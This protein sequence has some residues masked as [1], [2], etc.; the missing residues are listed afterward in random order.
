MSFELNH[1]RQAYIKLKSYI[2]HDNTDI[3]LRKNLAEFETNRV[4]DSETFKNIVQNPYGDINTFFN[5]QDELVEKKLSRLTEELNSYHTDPKFF[6]SFIENIKVKFYPKK[7]K[8]KGHLNNFITNKVIQENYEVERVTAFI[9]APIELHIIAVL[10][11]L[12]HGKNLDASLNDACLGNRLILN[13]EKEEVIQGSGL[14]KPYFHQYQKWR[15][16]SVFVAESLL[17]NKKDV[18]FLNLDIRDYYHSVRINKTKLFPGRTSKIDVLQP[19]YN[20]QEIFQKIHIFYTELVSVKYEVP[21]NL[22]DTMYKEEG[23]LSEIILPIGL[24]SSYVLGNDYLKDFDKRIIEKIKPAY[25][26]RYV[27]D[28]LIVISDPNPN[29]NNEEEDKELTFDFQKYS[30]YMNR[31]SNLPNEQVSFEESDLSELEKYILENFYPVLKIVDSPDFLAESKAPSTIEGRV[32]KI[33]SYPSLYCQSSKSLLYYFDYKES[34]LVIDKLKKELD[35]RTS[36]FRDFPDESSNDNTFEESAYHLQY[37]GTNGKIRTLKDYKENRFGLT[38][39]LSNKIF[40][41]L[42]HE[43][44][45]SEKEKDQVLQFFRGINCINFHRLWERIFTF[46]LVNNQATAYVDFYLHCSSQIEN[47]GTQSECVL[48]TNVDHLEIRNTLV[49]YLDCAHELSLS[50]NPSFIKKTQEAAIN[51]KY[52]I[53]KLEQQKYSLFNL[54]FEPTKPES[55]W[56]TRFRETNMVRHQYIVHPLLSYTV[57]SKQGGINLTSLK[58]NFA[59]YNFDEELIKSSPRRVKYWECCLATIFKKLSGFAQSETKIEKEYFLTNL[60]GINSNQNSTEKVNN[61]SRFYLDDAFELYKS[62]NQNHIPSY[63]MLDDEFKNKFFSSSHDDLIFD[64]WKPLNVQEIRVNSHNN[65]QL[66][67]PSIAFA[68]TE[69]RESNILDSIR[70]TP[71]LDKERYQNLGKVLKM[72]RKDKTDILLFP[73]CYIPINL[74]SSLVKHSAKEQV[75]VVSGLEHIVIDQLA[76]NFIVTILPVEV[77]GIKDA[78]VVIRLKNHYSPSEELLI[79]G[80]HLL[81]PKPSPYRYDIFIWRNVYLAPY[82]C[83]ELANAIHRN[84]FKG[85]VDLLIG[86]EWNK[87]TPYFSNIVE[88]TSRDLH[89]FIAQVN[90]SQYGDTRLTQPVESARKDIMRLKGGI[91]DAL[92]VSKINIKKLREFQRQKFS[93]THNKNEFKPLPPDYNLEDVLRRIN[94]KSVI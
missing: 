59:N 91:N 60:L 5:K 4:K 73:E 30:T 21:Y 3:L 37:D 26:G 90:T 57:D 28:I 65:N 85:K 31:T 68:N 69:V 27:D 86:V 14:F 13:K 76:F 44:K 67:E 23:V 56:I 1:V 89:A 78:V 19:Y 81:T 66:H 87:D 42:R 16:D 64:K 18:L 24:L 35:E 25:Y 94:N 88:S 61:S 36:E 22:A 70:S 48:G 40:S 84:L 15:D 82:Y 80:N 63:E 12:K 17:K 46:F 45:I 38:L 50:L 52:Q 53:G 29:Y 62:I 10:W 9:D 34:S 51:F 49:D 20:L 32:I 79:N 7:I 74:L 6:N 39:Y 55:Y 71:N 83:F 8:D 11:I 72:A 92:L 41:A 54:R 43:N 75:L 33:S 58:I 47:I 93:I 77:N 2:Y